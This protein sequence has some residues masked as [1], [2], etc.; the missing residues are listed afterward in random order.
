MPVDTLSMAWRRRSVGYAFVGAG[1]G[2]RGLAAARAP[3]P[4]FVGGGVGD[5]V[6]VEL[7]EA[8]AAAGGPV[9]LEAFAGC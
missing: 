3:L 8:V 7:V 5:T 9:S 1:G 2:R 4:C 6:A